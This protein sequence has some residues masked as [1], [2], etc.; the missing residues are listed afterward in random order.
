[1][2]GTFDGWS[3]SEKL[4]KTG[5]VFEKDVTLANASEKIYYKVRGET[6]QIILPVL[7]EM[8]RRCCEVRTVQ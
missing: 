3:K 7:R 8:L 6:A 2:T 5:D 4:V 1:M